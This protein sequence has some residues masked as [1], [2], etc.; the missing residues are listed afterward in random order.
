MLP[1]RTPIALVRDHVEAWRRD[2]RWSRETVAQQIV[3][4]HERLGLDHLTGIHFEPPTRDAFERMRV[5]ADK[6]FRWL[7]DATKDRNL[8]T[9]NFLWAILAA[10]PMDR[11]VALAS[12]LL[13]PVDLMAHE[14]ATIIGV[15]MAG[16][17]DRTAAVVMHFRDVLASASEAQVAMASMLD[18]IDPGEPEAAKVKLSRTATAVQRAISLMNR[19]L[20]RPGKAA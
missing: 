17:P 16:G 4:T 20:R 9:V 3:E 1:S 5:N 11:R 13:A 14:E 12:A 8:L 18:R 10:M 2:N 7:D 19:L 6:I 15:D